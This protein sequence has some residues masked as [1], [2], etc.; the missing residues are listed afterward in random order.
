MREALKTARNNLRMTQQQVADM[1]G[2][3]GIE[4]KQ[5]YDGAF[6]VC[7]DGTIYKKYY[8]GLYG[9]VNQTPSKCD[10]YLRVSLPVHGG[11]KTL[12][13]HRVIAEAFLPNPLSYPQ[14][15]H[16]DG[17]KTN[18]CVDNLEWCDAEYNV[19]DAVKRHAPKYL[20][21]MK[22]LRIKNGISQGRMAVSVGI[23]LGAYRDIENAVIM[24]IPLVEKRLEDIFGQDIEYLLAPSKEVTNYE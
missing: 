12:M 16:I 22:C 11:G 24:P 10:G 21:N 14:V 13:A 9:I 4:Y 17:D 15:N 6:I 7:Y 3:E 8:D 5:V 23:L 2:I 1:L 20:T 19:R 18:N